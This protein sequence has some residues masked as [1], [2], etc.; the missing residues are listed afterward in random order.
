MTRFLGPMDEEGVPHI[1]VLLS[2]L[3]TFDLLLLE[4]V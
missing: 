1:Y 4:E 2:S 3:K